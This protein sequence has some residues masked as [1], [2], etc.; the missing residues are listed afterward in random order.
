M[1]CKLVYAIVPNESLNQIIENRAQ[2]IAEKMVSDVS[3]N[4]YLEAQSVSDGENKRQI[5]NLK[6]DLLNSFSKKFWDY[7][8]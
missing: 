2:K 4:M 7:E 6:D 3:H 5:E 1:E 8:V